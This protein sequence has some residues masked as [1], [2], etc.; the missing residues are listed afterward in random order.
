MHFILA[1]WE[2]SYAQI[3]NK[4]FPKYTLYFKN[5]VTGRYG[6]LSLRDRLSNQNKCRYL[7]IVIKSCF[8]YLKDETL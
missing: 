8:F 6:C 7:G 3:E 5:R 4:A 1:T 2:N